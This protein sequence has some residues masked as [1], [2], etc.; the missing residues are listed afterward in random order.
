MADRNG[1]ILLFSGSTGRYVTMA[2]KDRPLF[3]SEVLAYHVASD[4]WSVAGKMPTA[5]ARDGKVYSISDTGILHSL[6][7]A[8]TISMNI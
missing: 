5:V 6:T 1:R 8:L 7:K 3:P 2:V 4:S